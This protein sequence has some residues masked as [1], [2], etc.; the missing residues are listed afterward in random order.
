M[1]I[2][3]ILLLFSLWVVF[4]I[5]NER[6][7]TIMEQFR[8]DPIVWEDRPCMCRQWSKATRNR[9]NI[10]NRQIIWRDEEKRYHIEGIDKPLTRCPWCGKKIKRKKIPVPL[11]L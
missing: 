9:L 7:S 8:K 2:F 3:D 1:D 5:Q 4:L 6:M 11:G 10:N